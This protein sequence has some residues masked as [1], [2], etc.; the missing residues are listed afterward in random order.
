MRDIASRIAASGFARRVAGLLDMN[1]TVVLAVAVFVWFLFLLMGG[2]L[3]LAI[4]WNGS[5]TLATLG[6]LLTLAG[7]G[8]LALMTPFGA[9]RLG[10][11]RIVVAW[12]R[13]MTAA[14]S[15]VSLALLAGYAALPSSEVAKALSDLQGTVAAGVFAVLSA[16][17]VLR[18]EPLAARTG[19]RTQSPP[20]IAARPS[21]APQRHAGSKS[22]AAGQTQL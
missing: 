11:P 22:K 10:G 1:A 18:L 21:T 8:S 20:A 15:G 9:A 17:W 5:S 3:L 14:A 6:A 16:I 7:L 13:G 19:G 12:F 4:G 2:V